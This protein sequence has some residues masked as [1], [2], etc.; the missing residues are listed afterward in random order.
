MA[1]GHNK[2]PARGGTRPGRKNR[3]LKAADGNMIPQRK[4]HAKQ[5]RRYR[6][7]PEDGEVFSVTL[8]G[9]DAWAL[10][11]LIKAGIEGV[12]PLDK[13]APRWSAYIHRLR[14]SGI[15]IETLREKHGGEFPGYHARYLLRAKVTKGG[16]Q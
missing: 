16:A 14:Q 13:P 10:M 15:P 11:Q 9:R 3:S 12:A 8:C 1:G 7:R 6:I 4:L 2:T 5:P